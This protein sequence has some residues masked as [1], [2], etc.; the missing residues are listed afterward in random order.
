MT[1]PGPEIFFFKAH[2]IIIGAVFCFGL[3]IWGARRV[4][5]GLRI[6]TKDC[7]DWYDELQERRSR[8]R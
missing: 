4:L 2:Q 5:R 7:C 6:L 8:W 1:V 3:A